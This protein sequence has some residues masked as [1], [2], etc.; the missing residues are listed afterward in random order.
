MLSA[1]QSPP[2]RL[3]A[4]PRAR[5][6]IPS[7]DADGPGNAGRRLDEASS[8]APA[9]EARAGVRLAEGEGGRGA[10]AESEG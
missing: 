4:L 10:G 9:V 1:K 5:L 6:D 7:A 3:L 2:H 8:S